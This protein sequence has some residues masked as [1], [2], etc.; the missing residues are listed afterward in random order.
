MSIKVQGFIKLAHGILTDFTS[1]MHWKC[2]FTHRSDSWPLG[3]CSEI[4]EICPTISDMVKLNWV[5]SE[6]VL[7]FVVP[8]AP[9][10][11]CFWGVETTLACV[12]GVLTTAV[13]YIGGHVE[14]PTYK[15][16]GLRELLQRVLVQPSLQV[17]PDNV[18]F[19]IIQMD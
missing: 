12:P 18:R 4:L 19:R 5:I 13:G 10:A 7:I 3:Y 14:N 17:H 6:G 11:G 9:H 1:I 15:Q 16:V 2:A 8:A